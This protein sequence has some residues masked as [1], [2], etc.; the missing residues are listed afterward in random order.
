MAV[1]GCLLH[2]G[3]SIDVLD[4]TRKHLYFV[5]EIG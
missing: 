1:M 5:V 4:L 3:S 2:V